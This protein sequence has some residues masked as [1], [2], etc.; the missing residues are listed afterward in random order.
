MVPTVVRH[1]SETPERRRDG[2]RAATP[3]RYE[4]SRIRPEAESLQTL[5]PAD[6]AC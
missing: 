6:P 1:A 3:M 2:V 4:R 5:A